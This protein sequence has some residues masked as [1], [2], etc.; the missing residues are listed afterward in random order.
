M[1]GLFSLCSSLLLVLQACSARK[2][3]LVACERFDYQR[4]QCFCT[5]ENQGYQVD[6]VVVFLIIFEFDWFGEAVTYSN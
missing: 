5:L 1:A 3:S 2:P 6:R 4:W